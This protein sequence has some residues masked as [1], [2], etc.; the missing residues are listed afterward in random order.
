MRCTSAA[1][2]SLGGSRTG[3]ATRCLTRR[4]SGT[5]SRTP[6]RGGLP[7]DDS[8]GCLG[9]LSTGRVSSGIPCSVSMCEGRLQS[10]LSCERLR[11]HTGALPWGCT[12]AR[13]N[14][15]TGLRHMRKHADP[16]W[17]GNKEVSR[18][19]SCPDCSCG[20]I[21]DK[22]A[23]RI[24]KLKWNDWQHERAPS[25]LRD[26]GWVSFVLEGSRVPP[27]GR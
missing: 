18:N 12:S 2:F 23:E 1:A 5:P 9:L 24:D 7:S 15:G 8:C 4:P 27:S 16:V 20:S 3:W 17:L 14:G 13:H 26:S 6:L 11:E 22:A 25:K 10:K 19:A 21:P